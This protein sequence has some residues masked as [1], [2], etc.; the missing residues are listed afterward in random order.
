MILNLAYISRCFNLFNQIKLK[1][2]YLS[3]FEATGLQTR[4]FLLF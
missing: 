1:L 4:R 2:M 3:S